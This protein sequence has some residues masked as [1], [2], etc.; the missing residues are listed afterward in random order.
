VINCD[1]IEPCHTDE[2]DGFDEVVRLLPRGKIWNPDR[3]GIYGGYISALGHIKTELNKRICQEWNEVN[4]CTSERLFSY[5]AKIYSLPAC[6]DQTNE[7][8]CEWIDLLNGPCPIGSLGFIQAAVDFVAPGKGISISVNVGEPGAAC[9]PEEL[10][11]AANRQIVVTAPP[12]AY[13]FETNAIDYPFEP[14]DAVSCRVY[15]IPEIECLRSC[16]FPFG[17]TLGYLTDS[18]GE[19][20]EEIF[21][22]P[23]QNEMIRPIVFNQCLI[24]EE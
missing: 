23:D 5:W 21:G 22:V 15:F 9:C 17:L 2:C 1:Y 3:G 6:V 16:V 4:P 12:E 10:Q 18:G 19:T 11:C 24:C 7:K 8:L 20:G 14:Q 13:F